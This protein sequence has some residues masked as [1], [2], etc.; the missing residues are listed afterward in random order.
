MTWPIAW[1]VSNQDWQQQAAFERLKRRPE[2]EGEGGEAQLGFLSLQIKSI[3]FCLWL[4]S[5]KG[6]GLGML[7]FSN[8]KMKQ[9]SHCCGGPSRRRVGAAPIDGRIPSGAFCVGSG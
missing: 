5:N 2:E 3:Y 9:S 1:K 6:E 7:I 4:N 8:P